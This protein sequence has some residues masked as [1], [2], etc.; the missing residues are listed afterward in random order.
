[1]PGAWQ[2]AVLYLAVA[3][4][5]LSMVLWAGA[6]Q[7]LLVPRLCPAGRMSGDVKLACFGGH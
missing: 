4:G 7:P 6:G 3:R 5:T 1:M 2:R